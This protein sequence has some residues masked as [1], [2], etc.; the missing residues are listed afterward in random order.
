MIRERVGADLVRCAEIL[1]AV[2]ELDGYPVHLGDD[3]AAFLEVPDCLGAWVAEESG[4]L[5]GHVLLRQRAHDAVMA[6]AAESTGRPPEALAVVGRLFV[7]PE[8][9]GRGIGGALLDAAAGRAF[10]IGRH[11]VL[12]VVSEH[13]RAIAMYTR[14]GWQCCGEVR[15]T[16][17]SGRTFDELVFVAP[18]RCRK[19]SV[20]D[21]GS[22]R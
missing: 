9:R 22:A 11:P 14:A 16:F 19:S 7:A 13:H 8:G 5:L 15:T 12:D 17:P 6:R 4:A 10:E 20:P 2:H 1:G 18:E 21:G 3:P